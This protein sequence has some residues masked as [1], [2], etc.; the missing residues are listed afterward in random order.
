MKQLTVVAKITAKKGKEALAKTALEGLIAPTLKEEGCIEYRLHTSADRPEE[1][2]F[3]ENW[4]SEAHL[5]QHLKNTHILD[6]LEVA[7]DLLDGDA[8]LS[9]WFMC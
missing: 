6:F 3:Y 9:K 5:Q 7:G 2:L 8:E 1:F 4:E